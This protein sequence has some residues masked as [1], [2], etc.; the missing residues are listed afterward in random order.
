MKKG[1]IDKKISIGVGPTYSSRPT[2]YKIILCFIPWVL[3]NKCRKY[4]VI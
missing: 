2:I 1:N 3:S 4:N